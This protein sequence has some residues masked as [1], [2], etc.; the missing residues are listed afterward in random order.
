MKKITVISLLTL[1]LLLTAT[2]ASARS[3]IS[4]VQNDAS[5]SLIATD[6]GVSPF[7][8]AFRGYQGRYHAQG[9]SGFSS[10]QEGVRRGK[11]KSK[12][13]VEA[14]IMAGD[15]PVENRNDKAYLNTVD[16]QLLGIAGR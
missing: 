6:S 12:E 14:A 8:L 9:I 13:L 10:F 2:T 5:I 4:E 16:F 1:P 11:I 15:I 7:E 3:R